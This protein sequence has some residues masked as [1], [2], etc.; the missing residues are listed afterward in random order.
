MPLHELEQEDALLHELE[1]EDALLH[2]LEQEDALLHELEQ[3]DALLH[4]LEQEDAMLHAMLQAASAEWEQEA[5]LALL[6]V[7]SNS[8][9]LL[10][11]VLGV[12]EPPWAHSK[13]VL[14]DD[15]EV[16][17]R[18]C[19]LQQEVAVPA[20]PAALDLALALGLAI[21]SSDQPATSLDKLMMS[22]SCGLKGNR[23]NIS[24][25]ATSPPMVRTTRE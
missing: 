24:A 4:E 15:D 22:W 5:T 16:P 10:Q 9:E 11:Q 21:R 13:L 25:N 1:Q 8:M 17:I 20:I 6:P 14:V 12:A 7:Q 19:W 2:E 18:S 23:S 3:E